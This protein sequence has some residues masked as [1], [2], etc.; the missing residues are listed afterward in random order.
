MFANG[1]RGGLGQTGNRWAPQEYALRVPATA[2]REDLPRF[3]EPMLARS[4]AAPGEA[5]WAGEVKWDGIRLQ[6]RIEPA[7]VSVRSR[8]GRDCTDLF[9][10]LGALTA[11]AGGRRRLLLDGELVC[12]ADDGAP[13]FSSVRARLFGT[14]RRA[15]RRPVTFVIFDVLHDTGRAVRALPYRTR[16]TAL[17]ELAPRGECWQVPP[18]FIGEVAE[19]A[20]LTRQRG[21]EGVV[22]KRM[23]STYVPGRR[24]NTWIKVKHRRREQ[25]IARGV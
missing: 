1:R 14:R 6:A 15:A 11:L 17:D 3:I 23:D 8:P 24:S 5:N 9:P 16:R 25:L 13:D 7:G 22:A 12:L 10:E 4:G 2:A 21:L 19:L 18:V 20:E